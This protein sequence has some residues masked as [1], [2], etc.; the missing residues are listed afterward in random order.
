MATLSPDSDEA[1]RIDA[2][3]QDWRQGDLALE[4]SWFVHV[5]DP[6]ARLPMPRRRPPMGT[7]K[8]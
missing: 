7:S 2:A 4:E 5:G 6:R 1:K 8:R 3:L